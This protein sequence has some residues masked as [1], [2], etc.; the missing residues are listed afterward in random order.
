MAAATKSVKSINFVIVFL[1]VALLVFGVMV[2]IRFQELKEDHLTDMTQLRHQFDS[3]VNER[4]RT[5]YTEI[6]QQVAPISYQIKSTQITFKN[7]YSF[8]DFFAEKNEILDTIYTVSYGSGICVEYDDQNYIVTARHSIPNA[9]K[10]E[11]INDTG[12][13]F[14]ADLVQEDSLADLAILTFQGIDKVSASMLPDLAEADLNV[15]QFVFMVGF[16][17][18]NTQFCYSGMIGGISVASDASNHFFIGRNVG[19]GMSGGGVFNHTG[20][21]LGIILTSGKTKAEAYTSALS[22][23][24]INRFFL[25]GSTQ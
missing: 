5:D 21:L 1:T 20:Q 18:G 12:E 23:K 2:T 25:S 14:D 4:Q 15:G 17:F 6:F 9:Q 11:I 3:V 24:E 19:S 7:K 10:I 8:S 13:I 22:L 16:P